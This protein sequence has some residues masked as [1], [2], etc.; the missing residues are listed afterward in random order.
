MQDLIITTVQTDIKWQD[1][2]YNLARI[3]DLLNEKVLKTDL[4]ILPEMFNTGFSMNAQEI[5]ENMDGHSISFLVDMANRV[6]AT[7]CGSL[8]IKDN[9]KFFNR[10]VFVSPDGSIEYYDK[11]HPFSFLGEDKVYTAGKDK[12]IVELKGWKICPMICYD[13]RFPAWCR[14]L[15]DYDLLIFV[16]NW[17]SK[18]SHHWKVLLQSRAIE[19]QSYVVGVNRVGKDD[20][21]NLHDG[22][23]SIFD[24]AGEELYNVV[25][26]EAIN[27][28]TLSYQKLVDYRKR[29]PFLNDRDEFEFRS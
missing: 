24:Y 18:R 6:Q 20:K 8:V 10:L 25:N 2:D 23:S 17:P 13:L 12:K 16:A 7:L 26:D 11:R 1:V 3:K 27:T 21:D 14:N 5:S 28:V 29:Y 4:I 9:G 22:N 15:E 19:N